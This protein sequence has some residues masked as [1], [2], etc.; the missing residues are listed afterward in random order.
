M[1]TNLNCYFNLSFVRPSVRLVIKK[2]RGGG[3]KT[4]QFLDNYFA[5]FSQQN[6]YFFGFRHLLGIFKCLLI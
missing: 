1:L 5:L 4:Q 2:L 6:T 3:I